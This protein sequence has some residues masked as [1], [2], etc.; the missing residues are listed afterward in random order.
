MPIPPAPK[1]VL[2]GA[3]W[4]DDKSV[5]EKEAEEFQRQLTEITLTERELEAAAW[6]AENQIEALVKWGGRI[7][8]NEDKLLLSG[9]VLSEEDRPAVESYVAEHRR[10]VRT[11][12]RLTDG[13]KFDG[14]E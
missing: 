5:D 3:G 14:G 7:G 8:E 10:F 6:K 12:N 2:T 9:S 11:V 1:R 13:L 4:P